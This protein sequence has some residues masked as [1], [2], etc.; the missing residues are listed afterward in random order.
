VCPDPA[1]LWIHHWDPSEAA[2]ALAALAST[3]FGLAPAPKTSSGDTT[4]LKGFEVERF[5]L[6]ATLRGGESGPSG[7]ALQQHRVCGGV[8]QLDGRCSAV[9]RGFG[10]LG[11]DGRRHAERF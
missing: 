7:V 8:I 9:W 10:G 11:R 4:L 5:F 1:A 3:G 6:G 2:G